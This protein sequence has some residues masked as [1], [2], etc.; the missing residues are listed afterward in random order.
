MSGRDAGNTCNLDMHCEHHISIRRL[1]GLGMGYLAELSLA[2]MTCGL[3][4]ES[5]T[6]EKNG[7]HLAPLRYSCFIRQCAVDDF[8]MAVPPKFT[9]FC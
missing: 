4:E 8:V 3:C 2:E 1:T 7:A 5:K 9:R 6:C